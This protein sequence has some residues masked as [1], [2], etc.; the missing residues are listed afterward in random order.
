MQRDGERIVARAVQEAAVAV[1]LAW[2]PTGD[3]E[4]YRDGCQPP[5]GEVSPASH[6]VPLPAQN[7]AGLRRQE[8]GCLVALTRP[9]V[10]GGCTSQGF[11]A[12][13]ARGAPSQRG[14]PSVTRLG[15]L[16]SLAGG[17]TKR[18]SSRD[19]TDYRFAGLPYR[20]LCQRAPTTGSHRAP[21]HSCSA[22]GSLPRPDPYG[23][24]VASLDA[25]TEPLWPLAYSS[26]SST[27][28]KWRLAP[29]PE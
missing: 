11:T 26:T 13:V 5:F 3:A 2:V 19:A 9:R 15:S 28:L 1:L 14:S 6:A 25:R 18:Q 17:L 8:R 23:P 22:A 12:S 20:T 7:K 10:L 27:L 21:P 29:C 16:F 24:N 4:G